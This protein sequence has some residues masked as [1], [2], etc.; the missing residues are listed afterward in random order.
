MMMNDGDDLDDCCDDNVVDD[1]AQNSY[2]DEKNCGKF[3]RI[4]D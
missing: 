3:W 4:D 2:G 1:D